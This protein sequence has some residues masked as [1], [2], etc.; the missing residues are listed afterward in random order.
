[1]DRVIA[2]GDVHGCYK[3][4]KALLFETIAITKEDKIYFLGDYIDRG[5]NSK[6]VIKKIIKLKEEG[7]NITCLMGNH[8]YMLLQSIYSNIDFLNWFRFGGEE[9]LKSFKVTHPKDIKKK[10]IDFLKGL[11]YYI[12]LDKFILVHGGLNFNIDEPL[13][14]LDSMLWIRNNDVNPKKINNKRIVVGHTPHSLKDI[15]KS[16]TKDRILLDGGCV[17]K[18]KEDL[19]YLVALDL[20][21]MELFY[22]KNIE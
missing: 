1:M 21:K 22:H 20:E 2:I 6:K 19:G 3:T 10:Y 11:K 5:P 17:Y 9:A 7:Y 14:D 4:L 18:H 16:L 15:K 8:E 13:T 12:E